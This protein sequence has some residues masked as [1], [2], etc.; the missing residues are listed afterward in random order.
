M[1]PDKSYD[2][3]GDG[4]VSGK[5]YMLSKMFDKNKDGVLDAEERR[6]AKEAIKNVSPT[7]FNFVGRELKRTLRLGLMRPVLFGL[8]GFCKNVESLSTMKISS[9]CSRHI[10]NT[11]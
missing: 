9:I 2:L 5:D 11:H 6:I 1:L 4:H 3:D 8:I 7:D 10:H